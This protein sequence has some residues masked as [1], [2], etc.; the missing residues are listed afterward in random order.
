MTVLY[1]NITVAK[2]KEVKT[3]WS[4]SRRNR[5]VWQHLLRKAVAQKG[6]S[7]DDDDESEEGRGLNQRKS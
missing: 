6:S 1:K 4:N 3:G 2:S 5:Q 7:A